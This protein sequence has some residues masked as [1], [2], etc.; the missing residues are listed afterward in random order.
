MKRLLLMSKLT[1]I[2]LMIGLHTFANGLSQQRISLK[3][4]EANV[5]NALHQI[6]KKTDYRFLYRQELISNAGKVSIEAENA[7]LTDVLNQIFRNS[8]IRYHLLEGNL[9]ALSGEDKIP[10]APQTV[11]GQVLDEDGNP[12][13]GAS[14]SVKGTTTGVAADAEG[15][16]TITVPDD[17][18]LVISAVGFAPQEISIAGRT[19][20]DVVLMR[21]DTTNLNEVVVIGYGTAQKRDLTGSIVKVAGEEVADKPNTNPIASL[22]GKVAGL[23]VVNNGTPGARPDIRIRGTGSI[24]NVSPLYVVDG[25]LQDNIDYINP[26]DIESIEILKDPSSLAI[27]GVRGATGVIAITTKRAR[28]GQ[29]VVNFNTTYGF[30]NLVDKIEMADRNQFEQM[31]AEER[32]YDA[33]NPTTTPYDYSGLNAN[34]DWIDAVTRVGKFSQ[35]NLSVSGSSE[36][37]KFNF[38]LGYQY[39]EG[40]IRHEQLSKWLISL[41]DEFRLNDHIRIGA[42]INVSRQRNPYGAGWVLDAARKVMPHISAETQPFYVKNPYGP[43]SL[44]MDLYSMLDVG[45]QNSGV[46]NPLIQLENEWDKTRSFE[47]RTV[48]SVFAEFDF[49]KNFTWRSSVYADLSNVNSRI[50]TPLYY[51]YNPRT[52]LPEMYSRNTRVNESDQNWKKYQQDHLLSYKTSTGGHNFNG[53]AGLTT[54]YSGWFGRFGNAAQQTGP[55][56]L[57]IPNDPRFWYVSNGFQDAANTSATSGQSEYTTVSALARVL[58]NYD[59][60]YYL[61]A[62]WR[63]D[64]S[65]RLPPENRNQQFWAVG[66]AWEPS[67]EDF[68]QDFSAIDLL[69]IKGSIGVL[70]NQTASRLDGSPLDYPFYP[71]LEGG[72]TA[73][74]GTNV[75]SAARRQ[76]IPNPNLQWETVFA[77]EIGLELNAWRNRLHFEANYF[78]RMTRDL[79]TFVN[80]ETIG[81]PNQLI[82]GGK[83]RNTGQEF[84]A[85]WSDVSASGLRY[86]F[87]GNITFLQNEVIELAPELPSGFLSRA[88]MNNGS[89]EART[90]PG[91]PIGAFYGYVV[92]GIY[93][94]YADILKSPPAGGVGSYRPGSFKFKDVNGDGVITPDDRTVIGNPTPDFTYGVNMTVGYK[95]LELSIDGYGVYGNEIFRTWASLESPFQ[96]VNYALIQTDRWHGEGTSNWTPNLGQGDRFNYNGSTFNIEDGSFFRLRN[97]QL[98]Y[99]FQPALMER[100]KIRNLRVFVNVQNLKTWKN[101]S[102]YTTE[103][104]GDATSFGFDFAGGAIPRVTTAG[105]NV[106]F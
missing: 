99:S 56:G 63:N 25:I 68:M 53:T 88:H 33:N 51:A 49:L 21:V 34:T 24:G 69:K 100:I 28:A 40:I 23:S 38:G 22:Q 2:F 94:S 15:N 105:I 27:F 61:N 83:I 5:R 75:Y 67:R 46:V 55:T 84:T 76:Y 89:A 42:N 77:K 104:G 16:Y 82:N 7:L 29:T 18:V 9:I 93:Q 92:E 80:R 39:D 95:G 106:T 17:G 47:L 78:N 50:Y 101:N 20:F 14:I 45:L 64:A 54:Y 103:Y 60:K 36:R 30:K 79:M 70:G 62:S 87:G 57:P 65:S 91:H 97:V 1:L 90:M 31:F 37:N 58:Y 59:R 35:S 66:A 43:D 73:V 48:G 102:G 41:S 32:A 4:N 44:N 8:G 11:T 85:S 96:R 26:N 81:L 12:L 13:P 98:A 72:V 19:N 10:F 86:N 71:S 74:F 52:N 6:E 3:L